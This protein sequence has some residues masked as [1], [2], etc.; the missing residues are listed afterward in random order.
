MKQNVINLNGEDMIITSELARITAIRDA[1]G[2]SVGV[3]MLAAKTTAKPAKRYAIIF[4]HPDFGAETYGCGYAHNPLAYGEEMSVEL[5][6]MNYK[7]AEREISEDKVSDSVWGYAPKAIEES[8]YFASAH[9]IDAKRAK[10]IEDYADRKGS[11]EQRGTIEACAKQIGQMAGSAKF[12]AEKR[13]SNHRVNLGICA[14][15]TAISDGSQLAELYYGESDED[16]NEKIRKKFPDRRIAF[17]TMRE[18]NQGPK[19]YA[20]IM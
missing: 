18:R 20:A 7:L 11:D 15:N 8:R 4:A 9:K 3:Y 10:A 5:E 16:A 6:V 19:I 12:I 14:I 2:N 1:D 13:A 17:L